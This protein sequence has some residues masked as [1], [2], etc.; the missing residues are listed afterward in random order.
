MKKVIAAIFVMVLLLFGV[1]LADGTVQAA[2]VG[3]STK[4]LSYEIVDSRI[5][6]WED[7]I[8]SKLVFGFVAVKNTDTKPIYLAN[9]TFDYEDDNGHLISSAALVSSCPNVI[10]P[11]EIGYYYTSAMVS[12]LDDS[13]DVSNGLNLVAQFVLE[14]AKKVP[15]P[16]TVLDTAISTD[17]LFKTPQFTGRI[18]NT[19]DEDYSSTWIDFVMFDG[20]GKVIFISGSNIDGPYGGSTVGFDVSFLVAPPDATE[21]NIKSYEVI[22]VPYYSQF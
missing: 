15:Q 9:C 22:A 2:G 14:E 11:G 8:G 17:S 12:M 20:E 1:A 16:F 21:E 13:A 6:H 4:T 10:N 18:R 5:T 3:K 7:I 19:T